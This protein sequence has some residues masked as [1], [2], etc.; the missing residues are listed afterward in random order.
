MRHGS[1]WQGSALGPLLGRTSL[2]MIPEWE[3]WACANHFI[4]KHGVDA[5]VFAAMRADE[6]LADGDLQG[7][8]T[9]QRIA[10][11]INAL[12]QEPAG[13]LH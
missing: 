3:I 7:S 5:A 13:P 8:R 9:F 12:L 4:K 10:Q 1:Q 2:P 6:L 11:K